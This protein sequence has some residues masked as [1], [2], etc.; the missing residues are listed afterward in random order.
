MSDRLL[1]IGGS[2]VEDLQSARAA[3][4][5]VTY[6][7]KKEMLK[8]AHLAL[9]DRT[10]VL[11]YEDLSLLLPLARTLHRHA[12]FGYVASMAESGLVPAARVNDDLH[13]PGTP[14]RTA[15]LLKDKWVMRRHLNGI[16]LST[17]RAAIGERKRDIERFGSDG[18]Y[19]V[20]VKPVDASGSSNVYLIRSVDDVASV[21]KR[22]MGAGVRRFLLEEY[23]EG[24]EIS[25]ESLSFGGHHVVIAVTGKQTLPNFVECGHVIPAQIDETTMSEV[26]ALTARFLDAVGLRHGPAHTEIKLTPQ[27]PRI[28]ESHNRVGGDEINRMVAEVYRIDMVATAFAWPFGKVDAVSLPPVPRKAVAIRFFTPA[29]GRV[30]SIDGVNEVRTIPAVIDLHL[31]IEQGSRVDEVRSSLD[32]SGHLMVQAPTSAEA[33]ELCQRLSNQVKIVMAPD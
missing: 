31:D 2:R 24:P 3:G 30:L 33:L 22:A 32:R 4:L 19:P 27:G 16:G 28:L 25:V 10:L 15:R 1:V 14:A 21:W 5:H 17:V 23:L 29:P 13:L 8:P 7:Q 11:D 20:I 18:G 9:S 12:P 6:V 26:R